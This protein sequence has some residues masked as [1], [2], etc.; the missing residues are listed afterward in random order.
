VLFQVLLEV[1]LSGFGMNVLG[2]EGRAHPS[3]NSASS[4]RVRHRCTSPRNPASQHSGGIFYLNYAYDEFRAGRIEQMLRQRLA[5]GHKL[6]LRDI[7]AMQAET[8]LLD[9]EYSVPYITQAFADAKVSS[10][11]QLA[12]LAADPGVAEAVGRCLSA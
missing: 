5:G 8:T 6:S 3:P 11:P 12:A 9:A 4:C 2:V 10:V 7:Q 1:C